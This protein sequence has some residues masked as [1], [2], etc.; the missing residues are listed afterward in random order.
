MDIDILLIQIT[1]YNM[2]YGIFTTV[3][4]YILLELLLVIFRL[5]ADAF[6]RKREAVDSSPYKKVAN[7]ILVRIVL[8]GTVIG[9]FY[10]AAKLAPASEGAI[11]LSSVV[12]IA[13]AATALELLVWGGQLVRFSV[14]NK[15][16]KRGVE[17]YYAERALKDEEVRRRQEETPLVSAAAKLPLA[18]VLMMIAS[19]L[20]AGAI[21]ARSATSYYAIDQNQQIKELV[22]RSYNGR[23]I[24]RKYD[25]TQDK[26]LPG[27][28][29][30]KAEDTVQFY[31]RI[32]VN[33]EGI[34]GSLDHFIE[35]LMN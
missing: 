23:I 17:M 25:V 10:V 29:L 28:S 15:G 8:Y 35:R 21:H 18:V 14:V 13:I 34:R 3:A 32:D 26:F 7:S 12:P 19:A 30:K 33:K 27:F 1:P 20:A 31:D 4:I 11:P 6:A 2:F 22:I 9:L 16:F 24:T 5:I